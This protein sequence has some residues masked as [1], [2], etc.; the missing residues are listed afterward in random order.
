M[1]KSKRTPFLYDCKYYSE[2]SHDELLDILKFSVLS[3]VSAL[4]SESVTF[5]NDIL[6]FEK[7]QMIESE[8]LCDNKTFIIILAISN[9][10]VSAICDCML[11]GDGLSASEIVTND[12][13]IGVKELFELLITTIFNNVSEVSFTHKGI[14]QTF[15]EILLDTIFVDGIILSVPFIFKFPGIIRCSIKIKDS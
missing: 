7:M 3:T 13:V 4:T 14:L 15:D 11:G 8:V 12:E 9:K 6:S 5:T 10:T 2:I 1:K